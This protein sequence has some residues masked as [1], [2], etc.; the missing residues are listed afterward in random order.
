MNH[1]H[2]LP[3]LLKRSMKAS[4]FCGASLVAVA[5]GS[6]EPQQSQTAG[7]AAGRDS[8]GDRIDLEASL[9]AVFSDCVI[10]AVLGKEATMSEAKSLCLKTTVKKCEGLAPENLVNKCQEVANSATERLRRFGTSVEC[11][12][13]YCVIRFD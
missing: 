12:S 13:G 10:D 3:A 2:G 4:L 7:I 9:E 6:V 11:D 5:C 8:Q 1:L